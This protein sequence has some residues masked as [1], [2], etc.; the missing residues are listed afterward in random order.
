M[1]LHG[2]ENFITNLITYFGENIWVG[3]LLAPVL[4][5]LMSF[6][7]C[8]LA[9]AGIAMHCVQ[10]DTKGKRLSNSMFFALG[11]VIVFAIVALLVWT[12][13][14]VMADIEWVFH[15]LLGTVLIVVIVWAMFFNKK[16]KHSHSLSVEQD[17]AVLVGSLDKKSNTINVAQPVDCECSV[18]AHDHT[19]IATTKARMIANGFAGAVFSFPCSIPV[20]LAFLAFAQS[21]GNY[22]AG[23]SMIALYIIGHNILPVIA[24][25]SSKSLFKSNGISKK[26]LTVLRNV[27]LIVM[28][29]YAGLLIFEGLY[30]QFGDHTGHVH[31]HVLALASKVI[32]KF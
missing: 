15:V 19:A 5:I 28:L 32:Q 22:V 6:T 14:A 27:V 23:T 12:L 8:C 7:P 29:F 24:G 10:G 25:V 30:E 2:I 13:G 11:G 18:H 1:S 26:V 3:L 4:G 20:I 16:H 21:S 31:E 9:H 17:T